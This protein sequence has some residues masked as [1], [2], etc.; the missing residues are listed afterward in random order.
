MTIKINFSTKEVLTQKTIFN[1]LWIGVLATFIEFILNFFGIDILFGF[2]PGGFRL[3]VIV[4]ASV[5]ISKLIIIRYK[6]REVI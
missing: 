4:M 6:G 2:L 1:A 5:I 3:I